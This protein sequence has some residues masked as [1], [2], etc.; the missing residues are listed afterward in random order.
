MGKVIGIV[1]SRRRDG[2][3]DLKAC[4]R[5]FCDV[6][7][8]GDTIV[9]GGCPK[10]GDRFAE[11]IA[12][13]RGLSITIH[14]PNWKK[15]GRGAGFKRNTLIANDCDILIAVVAP[16]RKGGTEDTIKKCVAQG[17]KVYLVSTYRKQ[18]S[19]FERKVLK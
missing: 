13:Q 14:F 11:W 8:D 18:Q 7:E 9:S 6:Y 17:K 19:L 4:Y 5:Q 16:D 3:D 15:Y 10:G 12:K 1:G 2:I